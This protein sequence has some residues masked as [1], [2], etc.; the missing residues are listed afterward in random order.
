MRLFGYE[1]TL[2]KAALPPGATIN[3]A[4]SD[5]LQGVARQAAQPSLGDAAL[6]AT[7]I[8]PD[9]GP[10]PPASETPGFDP[11]RFQFPWGANLTYTPRTGYGTP[12]S[13]LRGLAS[14]SPEIFM[15][16]QTRKDQMASLDFDFSARDK[17]AKGPD[18]ERKVNQARAF[19]AKPD[20][21]TPFKTWIQTGVDDVLTIDALSIYKRRTRGGDLY[22]YELIDGSTIKVLVDNRGFT[23][24]APNKAYRQIL[25][26]APSTDWTADELLY[27]PKNVRTWSPYGMSPTEAVLLIVTAAINRNV[28][29]LSY[30]SEGNIPNALIGVPD[31]WTPKDINAFREYWDIVLRGDPKERAGLKFV[32]STMAKSVH[33]FQR[34]DPSTSW[35]LWLLKVICACFGVTP[36]EV[37]FTDDVNKATSKTQGDVNQRRGVKPMANYW[38]GIFDSML[39]TDL[40]LPDIETTWSGGEG[41]DALSKARIEDLQV[42]NGTK[43]VDE[44]RAANGDPLVGV[45]PAIVTASGPVLW[46]DIAAGSASNATGNPDDDG[47]LEDAD[48]NSPAADM[49]DAA[50]LKRAA[51]GAELRKYRTVALKAAKAGRAVPGFTSAVIPAP[52]QARLSRALTTA[53]S[54]AD[55]VNVFQTLTVRKAQRLSRAQQQAQ[56]RM[57]KDLTRE[58]KQMGRAFAAHARRELEA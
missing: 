35:Q 24:L 57:A 33:E 10:L 41:D 54:P 16:V 28:H 48:I 4:G 23:P 51:L 40:G 13:T 44:I 25:Y 3:A 29:D 9:P 31:T 43:S 39:A 5:R 52:L 26:G 38:K 49:D 34:F 12:F 50:A 30:F 22:G 27:L 14:V 20:R 37:G 58:L 46:S 45:G 17:K 8:R 6:P 55:V 21:V 1:L 2:A 36:S 19:F 47:T 15:C 53:T 42:R 7:G 11:L 18:V 32:T 56:A